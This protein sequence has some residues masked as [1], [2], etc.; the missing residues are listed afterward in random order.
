MHFVSLSFSET[1]ILDSATHGNQIEYIIFSL[2]FGESGSATES[3]CVEAVGAVD[4]CWAY[5]SGL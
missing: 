3:W 4:L 5:M 1:F 2:L